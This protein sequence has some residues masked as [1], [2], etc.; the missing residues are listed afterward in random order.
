[1][2]TFDYKFDVQAPLMAVSQFHHDLAAAYFCTDSCLRTTGG[3]I[4]RADFTLWFGPLH[5]LGC[6]PQ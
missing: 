3:S 1:M 6:R 4:L 2:L 5:P